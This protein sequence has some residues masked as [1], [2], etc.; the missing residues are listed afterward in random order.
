MEVVFCMGKVRGIGKKL[1]E[2][3]GPGNHDVK[4]KRLVCKSSPMHSSE[5]I[6][7]LMASK[8]GRKAK[9]K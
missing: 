3:M 5:V 2:C 1:A 4:T 7:S 9:I 6:L 8:A